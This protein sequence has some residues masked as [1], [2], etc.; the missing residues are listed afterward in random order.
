MTWQGPG[1]VTGYGP[2]LVVQGAGSIQVWN[3]VPAFSGAAPTT[4]PDEILDLSGDLVDTLFDDWASVDTSALPHAGTAGECE[5][6]V[7]VRMCASCSPKALRYSGADQLAPE[8]E[9]VWAWFDAN[10]NVVA[11]VA[12]GHPRGYCAL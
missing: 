10:V 4:P 2:A 11:S 3:N 1:G 5:A 9:P 7:V 12:A 6:A 8:M